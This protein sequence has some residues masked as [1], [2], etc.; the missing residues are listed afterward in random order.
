MYNHALRW[1]VQAVFDVY[2][3][4]LHCCGA[5]FGR[6]ENGFP[7]DRRKQYFPALTALPRRSFRLHP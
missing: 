3:N 1:L 6:M 5:I 7:Q 4:P 2:P